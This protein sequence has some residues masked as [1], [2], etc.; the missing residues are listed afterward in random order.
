MGSKDITVTTGRTKQAFEKMVNNVT[1]PQIQTAVQTAIQESRI[2]LGSV[3][4]YYP[5]K[6]KAEVLLSNEETVLCKVPHMV[7]GDFIDFFVPTGEESYCNTLKEP[8]ILPR[9]GLPCVVLNIADE[10]SNDYFLLSYYTPNDLV[11]TTP[12]PQGHVK[13]SYISATNESYIDFGWDGL[14]IVSNQPID[15]QYGEDEDNLQREEYVTAEQVYTK[16]E[17]DELINQKIAEA[18]GGN[19]E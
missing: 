1:A 7:M 19:E 15:S 3:I 16:E 18:L 14:K 6:D 9:D 17:V 10:D 8:C 2:K 11:G 5:Y 4:K 13:L 12:P